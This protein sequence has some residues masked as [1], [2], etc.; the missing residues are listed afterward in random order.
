MLS[1]SPCTFPSLPQKLHI[2]P[3]LPNANCFLKALCFLPLPQLYTLKALPCKNTICFCFWVGSNWGVGRR[4][5]LIFHALLSFPCPAENRMEFPVV[6]QSTTQATAANRASSPGI[7]CMMAKGIRHVCTGLWKHTSSETSAFSPANKCISVFFLQIPRFSSCHP[8]T[9]ILT[10]SPLFHH[11]TIY[12][13]ILW[14]TPAEMEL[15]TFWWERVVDKICCTNTLVKSDDTQFENILLDSPFL[16]LRILHFLFWAEV[17]TCHW[18]LQWVS[19]T[20]SM[21][22]NSSLS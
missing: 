17:I 13:T 20:F 3:T 19:N 10:C 14:L 1:H 11:I 2:H 9:I 18:F 21:Q 6:T 16:N 15:A 7:I 5:H 4:N 12:S 22:H 8:T